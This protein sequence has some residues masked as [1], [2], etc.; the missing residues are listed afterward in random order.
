MDFWT[1]IDNK[2]KYSEETE[3][4]IA[5]ALEVH[6][7][8]R[9]GFSAGCWA[10]EVIYR[11]ALAIKF[12]TANISFEREFEMPVMYKGQQIGTRRGRSKNLSGIESQHRIGKSTSCS[13]YQLSRSISFR[14]WPS[15][16][17]RIR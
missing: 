8:L 5:A 11:R 12:S 16:K 1:M 6:K 7:F 3:K 14:N 10:Q 17:F 2:Y 4:I 9:N 13:G 15:T